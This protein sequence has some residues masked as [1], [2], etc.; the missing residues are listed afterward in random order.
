[1]AQKVNTRAES[2]ASQTGVGVVEFGRAPMPDADKTGV[3]RALVAAD[4]A[5]VAPGVFD[6]MTARMVEAC[7]FSAVYLGGFSTATV[8]GGIEPLLTL[9]EQVEAA[10]AITKRVRLPLL[11]DGHAGFGG[12]LNTMNTVHEFIRAD[13]AGIHIE[14]AVYPKRAA[15]HRGA[16]EMIPISEM[17]PKIR[18]A[19]QARGSSGFLVIGRTEARPDDIDDAIRR[20]SAYA[21]AGADVVMSLARDPDHCRR[22]NRALAG[23]P[24]MV[25]AL[26]ER[27]DG[28]EVSAKEYEDCGCKIIVYPGAA[29]WTAFQPLTAMYRRLRDTGRCGVAYS[30]PLSAVWELM[31]LDQFEAIEGPARRPSDVADLVPDHDN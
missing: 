9:T 20:L 27:P 10:R 13:V 18:A 2:E 25:T 30:E 11:A 24:T 26:G 15:D 31:G 12:P 1:M 5:I 7:G 19:V 22:I 4:R 3:L 8:G 29:V 6:P 23:V 28:L 17:V 21:E 14:D 16:A